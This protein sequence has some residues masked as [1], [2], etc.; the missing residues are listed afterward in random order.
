MSVLRC[1][2]PPWCT[3]HHL[4]WC[5][6]KDPAPTDAGYMGSTGS[7]LSLQSQSPLTPRMPLQTLH[8]TP[9]LDLSL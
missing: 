8:Q 2:K 9:P 5:G 4:D 1:Q 3:H 7:T 6:A